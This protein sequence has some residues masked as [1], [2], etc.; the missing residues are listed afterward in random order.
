LI[1]IA[2]AV[3]AGLLVTRA[4]RHVETLGIEIDRIDAAGLDR[5]LPTEDLPVELEPAA[6][7]VN[8]LLGRLEASFER[9][10]H[11]TEDVAHELR[12]PLSG[13][14]A[15]TELSLS[16]ERPAAGHRTAVAEVHGIAQEM[17]GMVESLLALTRAES[18]PV[19][20][21]EEAVLLK[22]L[23]D[24]SA[25]LL[26]EVTARRGLRFSNQIAP[27]IRIRT[28]PRTLRLV[29]QNLLAN[30]MTYTEP[31]GWVTAESDPARG[32]WLLVADSGPQL[33]PRDLERIFHR[34][35]RLDPSRPA[36]DHHGIG[37]ALVRT[38]CSRLGASV[39]AE[40]RGDGSLAFSVRAA[41]PG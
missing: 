26:S 34:F 22:D 27:D 37:L 29:T 30:A 7:K 24:G 5:R 15:V 11:F 2:A 33:P 1:S 25:A 13:L 16:R 3:L 32:L 41:T 10:R 40:N 35:V 17:L 21:T 12:T 6:S 28:D 8:Q 4:V 19:A 31:G 36:G 18:G 9:E 39:S 23:V 14:L 38:L 20:A